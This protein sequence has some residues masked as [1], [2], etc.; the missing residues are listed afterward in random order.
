VGAVSGLPVPQVRLR[1][2]A[3]VAQALGRHNDGDPFADPAGWIE[4]RWLEPLAEAALTFAQNENTFGLADQIMSDDRFHGTDQARRVRKVAAQRLHTEFDKLAPDQVAGY[5]KWLLANDPPIDAEGWKHLADRLR[6]RWTVEKEDAAKDRLAES[7]LHL[8]SKQAKPENVLEFLRERVAKAPKDYR[9]ERA[10]KLFDTLLEQPWKAAYEAEAIGLLEQLS[11]AEEPAAR[12][13]SQVAALHKLTDRMV[14]ARYDARMK[15]VEHPEKLTRLEMAAKRQENLRAAREGFADRLRQEASKHSKALVPWM[16]IERLYLDVLAGRNLEKAAEECWEFLGPE[17]RKAPDDEKPGTLLEQALRQRYLI[18][19]LHVT[20]RKT[21]KSFQNAGLVVQPSRLHPVAGETPAPQGVERVAKYL[22]RA[23][24][25]D[26]ENDRWKFLRM[27]SLVA[28]DRPKELEA[29]LRAWIEAGDP[30]NR[31]GAALG[32]LVAEQGRLQEAIERFE[33]IRAQD[34][35]GPAEHRALA[36]WYMAVG[37]RQEYQRAMIDLFKATDE[38]GLTQWL[39]EQFRPWEQAVGADPFSSAGGEKAPLPSE[40]D[41]QVPLVFTALLEKSSQPQQHVGQLQ[42]LYHAT[43]DFRLLAALV[44]AVV[45]HTAGTVYPLLEGLGPLWKEVRDEATVD[46]IAE[47]IAEVRKR[48]PSAVDQRA[49]DLLEVLSERRAAELQDQP[50]PHGDRALAALRRA[51]TRQWSPGEPRLVAGFL[52]AL[53]VVAYRPLAEAQI[54]A[55]E[56]LH[57]DAANRSEDRMH[58]ALRLANAYWAYQRPNQAIDLLEAALGEYQAGQGGILPMSTNDALDKLVSYL[59]QRGQFAKGEKLLQEQLKHPVNQQQIYWLTEHLDSLYGGAVCKGGSLSLG[60]GAELYRAVNRKIQ[61]DM[62]APNDK[63]RQNLVEILVALYAA[64]KEKNPV[65][66]ADDLRQFAFKRLPEVLKR[67]RNEYETIVGSVAN[68]LHGLAGPR[69]A[70]AFLIE[71]IEHE[72]ACLRLNNRDGWSQHG[73]QLAQWFAEVKELGD[74]EERLLKIVTNELR[75]DLESRQGR[76]R[77]LYAKHHGGPYWAA[78]AG[79]FAQI[80]EAVLERHKNS[81]AA[82]VY[83]ADYLHTGL[84]HTGRAVEILLDAHRRG[85]LDKNGKPQLAERLIEQKRFTESIPVLEP[86]VRR[87]PD[88]MGNR[89]MLMRAYCETSQ[90]DRLLALLKETNTH[91][92][93]ED[94][95]QENAIAAL[96]RSCLE[97]RLYQQAVGYY[98]EAISL[99]RRIGPRDGIDSTIPQYYKELAQAFAGL[100]KTSEAVDALCAAVVSWGP[101]R[102]QR[103]DILRILDQLLRQSPDLDGY[104]AR[105]DQETARTALDNPILRKA[106]GMVYAGKSERGKAVRQLTLAADLQPNDS[107]TWGKLVECHDRLGDKEGAIRDLLRAAQLSRRNIRH[108]ED[109]GNRLKALGRPDEAERA[110]T[111]T[112]EMLPGESE[113]HATLAEI[114]QSQNRWAEAIVQWE[115]VARLRALEP[116]GLVKLAEAQIHERRW[117]DAQETVRKLASRP[118]PPRFGDVENQIQE[119]QDRVRARGKE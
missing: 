118:W 68:A 115:H 59:E 47:R 90:R 28:L 38:S 58:I 81:S 12:L 112:V 109:V 61:A 56:A 99:H 103:A 104:V 29:T 71:R 25:V 22:D 15:A 5:V 110:Y 13:A 46:L 105:L 72:P 27:Q 116:T 54:R 92:H 69:D 19:L 106:L 50:G 2:Q 6:R 37:R 11:D 86:L 108:Y 96:A 75:R 14:H 80:A 45:G 7:L 95:W 34:E 8:L 111:S 85:V 62:D 73:V 97:N 24:A 18:T 89:T 74:L 53:D 32:Y 117:A 100:G 55:L 33:A 64:A 42:Q 119:L 39:S 40:L 91:F 20:I 9:V 87:R 60:S 1:A 82:I 35:L 65:G 10:A 16:N 78:K 84:E 98:Q 51:L 101:H 31:W 63:H 79:V 114:R 26:P 41:A 17:P 83:V 70:L 23:I 67:Q 88:D 77:N 57:R 102:D 66:V 30:D 44:D 94:R 21:A 3:A 48:A 113:G 52:A 107:E 43:H 4:P 93:K 36:N 76:N 49:L